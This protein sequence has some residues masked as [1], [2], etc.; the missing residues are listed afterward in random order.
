MVS[1]IFII[2]LV[3]R[4]QREWGKGICYNTINDGNKLENSISWK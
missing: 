4:E 1:V 3:W 2:C